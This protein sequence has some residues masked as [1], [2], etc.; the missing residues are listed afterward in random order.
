M[1]ASQRL[2]LDALTLFLFRMMMMRLMI[3]WQRLLRESSFA[4]AR[5]VATSKRTR[6][7]PR[8]RTTPWLPQNLSPTTASFLIAV[9]FLHFCFF[10]RISR[11]WCNERSR[12]FPQNCGYSDRLRRDL[13]LTIV[14]TI[15]SSRGTI[16]SSS[17]T[18]GATSTHSIL[19]RW[20]LLYTSSQ[21]LKDP[22]AIVE[23]NFKRIIL[24]LAG[25]DGPSTSTILEGFCNTLR[26]L[27]SQAPVKAPYLGD[28]MSLGS[29]SS[30]LS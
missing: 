9:I 29:E 27:F 28:S 21:K 11:T 16:F 17:R 10:L 25:A 5:R 6:S 2:C 18:R 4:D 23:N 19:L 24:T 20:L 14:L 3:T 13:K 15:T 1:R 12:I 26:F 7:T 8:P 22:I 30:S